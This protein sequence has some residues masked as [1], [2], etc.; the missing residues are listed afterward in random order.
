[1]KRSSATFRGNLILHQ[2]L[3]VPAKMGGRCAETGGMFGS[4]LDQGTVTFKRRM[5]GLKVGRRTRGHKTFV[6]GLT[7]INL[8][9]RKLTG[10]CFLRIFKRHD[11]PTFRRIIEAMVRKGPIN[12][13]TPIWAD[14][15]PSLMGIA[16]CL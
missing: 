11:I 2:E 14:M 8:R 4:E 6:F 7:E 1:M 15:H 9:T 16:M 12:D 10:K 5:A 3:Q 13:P